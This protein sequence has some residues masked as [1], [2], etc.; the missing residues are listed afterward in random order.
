L[1]Q[2][3]DATLDSFGVA[4]SEWGIAV[5]SLQTG[6]T[7]YRHNAQ[8]P[9]IPASNTKLLTVAAAFRQWDPPL[10]DRH[11]TRVKRIL[12]YSDNSLADSLLSGLG[13][14][15]VASRSLSQLG[16]AEANYHQADG[17]G[18]SRRNA[19]TASSLVS[20]LAAM[21][22]SNHWALFY[23]SLP[24]AGQSGTLSARLA[25][26]A[27]QGQI[28][29]KTGTLTGVRALSG[30]AET[31][32]FGRVAFS[33]LANNPNGAGSRLVAAIDKIALQLAQLQQCQQPLAESAQGVGTGKGES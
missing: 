23:S 17:S 22:D 24:V 9:L 12:R 29:A 25:G 4:N 33:I 1:G 2:G 21:P 6:R 8:H 31:A 16:L 13:G 3:L 14:P 18:L 15:Q 30:Y 5:K 28:R 27:A 20:L 7:L 26:T 32:D 10:N 19:V 11:R